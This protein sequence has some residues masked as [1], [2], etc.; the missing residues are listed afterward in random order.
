M[1]RKL[2]LFAAVTMMVAGVVVPTGHASH[3]TTT[4]VSAGST[5]GNGAVNAFYAG[6]SQDGSRVFFTTAESLVSGDTDADQD[7]YERSGSTTTL[8]STGPTGGNAPLSASFAGASQDG[9][10]V[11]FTTGER[12][13]SG[14]TD[15]SDDIYERTGSTT[16]LISTGPAGGNGTAAASFA[17]VSEDGSRV[18]FRT[19][20]VLVSSGDTDARADLYARTGTSTILI[21][22]GPAG[23][24][25]NFDAT[26]AAAS[27][28][29]T[30]VVF[31]TNEP[32]VTTDTDTAADIYQRSG[33]TTLI[34]SVG[35]AGAGPP[36][37]VTFAGASR[38][39][40]HVWFQTLGAFNGSDQD[41]SQDIYQ[42][43]QSQTT[44]VSLSTT[45][46]NGAFNA[47]FTGASGD[48]THVFFATSES[49]EAGDT[50]TAPD[51]YQHVT[52]ST[53]RISTGSIGGNAAGLSATYRGS[54]F[55]GSRVWF[56]TGEV[57]EPG[58]TDNASD[59]YERAGSTTTRISTGPLGGNTFSAPATFAGAAEDGARVFFTTNEQLISADTDTNTDVYERQGTTT[60]RISTGPNGA[61]LGGA[62][63]A[64]S[65]EGSR[66][67]F[68]SIGQLTSNDADSAQDVYVSGLA[69]TTGY[70]RPQG[71]TPYHVPLVVAY[72]ACTIGN[73]LHAAPLAFASCNP[74]ERTS[75]F[76][77]VGTPD[78]NGMP[79]KS[80]GSVRFGAVLG[81]PGTP[82]DEAD[83]SITISLTDVRRA[84]DLLDYTGELR[85]STS[86]RVTD[87][88]NGLSG[89][90]PATVSDIGYTATV[91]CA[92]TGDTTVGST[93]SLTTTMDTLVP[94]SVREGARG[95][96]DAVSGVDLYDGGP[97]GDADTPAGNTLF[98]SDGFFVP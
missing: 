37:T 75:S 58:D 78:A 65:A 41:S 11:F 68:T 23:G 49:L 71:A 39:L 86:L 9:S 8:I 34:L 95:I 36:V 16:N 76:L 32:L 21:S 83:A 35:S 62:F 40:D 20:E 24:N 97:D 29:A 47:S 69:S 70:A 33:T 54:S 64:T 60:T 13:V 80:A 94:G 52:P 46:G 31:T 93:C 55:D 66:V 59:L 44:H 92:A 42:R 56:T 45:G 26:F 22:T 2:A 19:N 10:R 82:A 30:R 15:S 18:I 4:L 5:G 14:D 91:P 77:T 87:K 50:D 61:G 7:V 73:Q 89:T 38:D 25:G 90:D 96:F 85:L 79:A 74:P 63:A 27:L 84:T 51:V 53:T 57:L 98:V 48:G 72:K 17:A 28:D 88:S 1:D 81:N 12:L 43:A 3:G 6:S 67:Y